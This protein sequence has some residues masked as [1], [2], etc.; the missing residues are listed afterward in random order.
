[1][2]TELAPIKPASI[3]FVALAERFPL[4]R[5]VLIRTIVR[6]GSAPK[7]TRVVRYLRD[8]VPDV[9]DLID[10]A[11]VKLVEDG[12]LE[13]WGTYGEDLRVCVTPLLAE[14]MGLALDAS[15]NKWRN[16]RILVRGYRFVGNPHE[17]SYEEAVA[18][19]SRRR[20]GTELA[21]L[22][23]RLDPPV[24]LD[25]LQRNTLPITG[26]QA[27]PYPYQSRAPG[28]P[29]AVPGANHTRR[30][31]RYTG[32]CGACGNSAAHPFAC[33]ACDRPGI[34]AGLADPPNPTPEQEKKRL[35][36]FFLRAK[37]KPGLR[38]GTG[39]PKDTGR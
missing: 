31:P 21:D 35:G 12:L 6:L 5:D 15:G 37:T 23:A 1:L 34:T 20:P 7:L 29:D 22:F 2:N 8:R 39:G 10:E 33:L 28:G 32:V 26:V 19:Q 36:R 14:R 17:L 27:W 25:V 3:F 24:D 13:L 38:G 9:E 16:R 18:E 4:D 30:I 11:V